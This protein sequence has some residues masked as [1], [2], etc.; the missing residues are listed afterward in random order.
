MPAL[1]EMFPEP[2]CYLVALDERQLSVVLSAL[3]VAEWPTR[4]HTKAWEADWPPIEAWV[5][6]LEECLMSG[7]DVGALTDTIQAGFEQLH[8]DMTALVNKDVTTDLTDLL[9]DLAG[10]G[11]D[12][13]QLYTTAYYLAILAGVPVEVLPLPPELPPGP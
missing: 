10:L 4:W 12:V 2:R 3:R 11:V 9:T 13:L 8:T 1:E 5:A 6:G 7:C